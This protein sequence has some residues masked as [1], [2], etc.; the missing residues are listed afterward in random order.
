MPINKK[1]PEEKGTAVPGTPG[2]ELN[3]ADVRKARAPKG[4]AAASIEAS[5]KA[6]EGPAKMAAPYD[7]NVL[8]KVDWSTVG[9]P[10]SPSANMQ[11]RNRR[12]YQRV[13]EKDK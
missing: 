1:Y 6:G 2:P 12:T 3:A 13:F 11:S 4:S 7:G 10:S 8:G 5:M 9:R